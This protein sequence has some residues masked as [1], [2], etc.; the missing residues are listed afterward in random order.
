MVPATCAAPQFGYKS[1][2][3]RD[4]WPAH[5]RPPLGTPGVAPNPAKP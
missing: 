3:V 1:K 5:G 2:V 4:A